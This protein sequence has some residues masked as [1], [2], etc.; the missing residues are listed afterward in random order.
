VHWKT[1]LKTVV[2]KSKEDAEENTVNAE[3]E[4]QVFTDG[5]GV[6]GGI[7]SA[8]VLY[9]NGEEVDAATFYLGSSKDHTVPE[10]EMV[11][12]IMGMGMI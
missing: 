12:L 4:F 1:N 3:A 5:S 10:A 11:G 6:N 9:R 2:D 7:G 8:A